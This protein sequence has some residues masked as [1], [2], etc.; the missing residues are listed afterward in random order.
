MFFRTILALAGMLVWLMP[1]A[2]SAQ[3]KQLDD[4]QFTITPYIWAISLNGDLTVKGRKADVDASFLDTVEAADSLFGFLAQLDAR[5]GNWGAFVSPVYM[6]IGVDKDVG[7]GP[8]SISAD[9]TT[10]VTILEFGGT[11]RFVDL[12]SEYANRSTWI[13]AIAGGRYTSLNAE[14]DLKVSVASLG[15]TGARV[16][17]GGRDW[18]D[19]IVGARSNINLSD[20]F[21]LR[22]RGDVGGFG[23][24]SDFSWQAVG[25]IVYDFKLF[26]TD[27]S[28]FAGY[29]SLHQDFKDGTFAWDMNL[30]GPI[31]GLSIYF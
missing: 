15:L 17:E 9:V 6:K 1:A 22:L 4:W 26:G 5:K 23:V 31:L 28:T 16:S 29:R 19:P 10:E 8:L 2:L 11:Y 7:I 14:I 12:P 18:L 25:L 13:E 24:G 20:K 30:H 21:S 27:A 3:E